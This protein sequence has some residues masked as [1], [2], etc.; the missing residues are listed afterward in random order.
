[1]TVKV[2]AMS[3]VLVAGSVVAVAGCVVWAALDTAANG[4]ADEYR[5]TVRRRT[6]RTRRH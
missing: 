4:I 2:A 5:R 3:A 1:V 6:Q